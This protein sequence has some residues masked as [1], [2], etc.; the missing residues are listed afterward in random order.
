M[1][2][3]NFARS[4]ALLVNGPRRQGSCSLISV[5]ANLEAGREAG[6]RGDIVIVV[7]VL[8][9]SSTVVVGLAC[10][11]RS[12]IPVRTV[13]EARS[14]YKR[15][16][17]LVLAGEREGIKPRGFHLGNSPT[18]FKQA[19]LSGKTIVMTTSNGTV[20]LES[21]KGAKSLLVGSFLNAAAVSTAASTLS[22]DARGISII[23]GSR[24]GEIFLE[25]FLC[26]GLLVSN[27]AN[28]NHPMNDEA[29]AARLAWMSVRDDLEPVLLQ[30]AHAV[31]LESIGY[32]EDVKFCSRKDIYNVVPYLKADRLLNLAQ[33]R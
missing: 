2:L 31:Y 28:K 33:P 17:E 21:S 5:E 20:A 30:A 7:D 25:D 26:S 19:N 27:L 14:L 1:Y 29:I 6:S 12:I 22:R 3:L 18:E 15:D 24:R 9:F 16:R 10:E 8:R 23:L 4:L 32:G 13:Q 11:A